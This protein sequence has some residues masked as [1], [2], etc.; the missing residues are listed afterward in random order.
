MKNSVFFVRFQFLV[1]K[2]L[3]EIMLLYKNQLRISNFN[4]TNRGDFTRLRKECLRLNAMDAGEK[5]RYLSSL[6][7]AGPFIAEPVSLNAGQTD[8]ERLD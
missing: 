3:N 5:P 2:P 8:R 7:P 6:D 4:Q 1:C